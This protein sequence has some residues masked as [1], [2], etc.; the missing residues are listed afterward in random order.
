MK[1]KYDIIIIGSGPAGY[2]AAIRATQ[3]GYQVAIIE[4]YP[5]LGG[6]CTNVG[7]IPAK[8]LLDSSEHFHDAKTKFKVHGIDLHEE[9]VLNFAQFLKRKD[10][11]V[12]SNTSGLQYLMRK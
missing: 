7:C 8:A 9:P 1:E 2:T 11:V 10:E 3:L 4:K 5:V 12:T 6:T